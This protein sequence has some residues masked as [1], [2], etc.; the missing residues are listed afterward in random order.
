MNDPCHPLIVYRRLSI[1]KNDSRDGLSVYHYIPRSVVGKRTKRYGGQGLVLISFPCRVAQKQCATREI[2]KK[3]S[4]FNQIL[5]HLGFV[6]C[7][8]Y[9]K[10]QILYLKLE[11]G[12]RSFPKESFNHRWIM[13]HIFRN[14]YY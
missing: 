10:L 12:K 14:W 11:L 2:F 1:P 6:R 9:K 4:L 8:Q 7:M 5:T 3:K 13:R